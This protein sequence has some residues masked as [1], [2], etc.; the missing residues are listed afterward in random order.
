MKHI[1]STVSE[2][3]YQNSTSKRQLLTVVVQ[4]QIPEYWFCNPTHL[5]K[6]SIRKSHKMVLQELKEKK[7]KVIQYFYAV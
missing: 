1:K 2:K 5:L 7:K 3:F 6:T 4:P